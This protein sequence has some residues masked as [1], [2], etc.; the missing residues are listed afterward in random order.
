MMHA[1]LELH[2]QRESVYTS[3]TAR[4]PSL[5]PY[6]FFVCLL[7]PLNMPLVFVSVCCAKTRFRGQEG[8]E[9][10]KGGR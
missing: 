8:Q 3:N 6:F 1:I 9:G 7:A 10:R 4:A 2:K 5:F